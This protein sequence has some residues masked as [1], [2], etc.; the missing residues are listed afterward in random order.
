MSVTFTGDAPGSPTMNLANANAVALL[1]ALGL[2]PDQ[3]DMVGSVSIPEA[4]RALIEESA[5]LGSKKIIWD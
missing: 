5:A 4:R 3:S 1:G 2:D